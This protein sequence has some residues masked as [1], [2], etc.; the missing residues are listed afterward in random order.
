MG[1]PVSLTGLAWPGG[2]GGGGLHSE[3]PPA[4]PKGDMAG[5]LWTS[6]SESSHQ[7]S[8]SLFCFGHWKENNFI[9][10]GGKSQ[11]NSPV[12]SGPMQTQME[13]LEYK[14]I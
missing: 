14:V 12:C 2:G 13:Q 9:T 5:D 8:F 10:S 11:D 1:G 6:N 3:P 7:H 4:S